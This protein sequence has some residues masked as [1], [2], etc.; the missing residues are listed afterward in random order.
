MFLRLL[1]K[2]IARGTNVSANVG[3]NYAPAKFADEQEA[4]AGQ[5]SK[6]ALKAA[7]TRLLD[8]G[9]I[10]TEED[11]TKRS[12]RRLVLAQERAQ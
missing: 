3:P 1:D 9:R 2:F 7:M 8:S 5:V 6:A 4:K 10:R 11:P 12:R